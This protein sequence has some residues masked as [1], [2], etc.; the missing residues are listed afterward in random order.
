[1]VIKHFS[2]SPPPP[3]KKKKTRPQGLNSIKNKAVI[4]VLG[5]HA[6][7][8]LK[9]V[10]WVVGVEG[11]EIFRYMMSK[12]P[13]T[14]THTSNTFHRRQTKQHRV[15]DPSAQPVY[16]TSWNLLF[17]FSTAKNPSGFLCF[18]PTV[19]GSQFRRSPVDI[20]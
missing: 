15:T 4:W 13:H 8:N 11:I 5:K 2:R 20:W 16:K 9:R 10:C 7:G 6:V 18:F 17:F 14:H 1:M 12:H 19:D 3:K